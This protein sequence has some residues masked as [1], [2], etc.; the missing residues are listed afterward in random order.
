MKTVEISGLKGVLDTL[1]SLPQEVVFKRGSPVKLALKRGAQVIRDEEKARLRALQ[2][3][4]GRN[5]VT[6]LIEKNLIDTRGKPPTE[7]KG[8]RYVVRIKKKLYVGRKGPAVSTVKAAQIF[9]YGAENNSQPARPFIRTAFQAKAE[10]AINVIAENL[11]ARVNRMVK[12]MANMNK[13]K[14]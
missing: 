7:F 2:N 3:E 11:I 5:D 10:E 14:K 9:E 1:T 8:E 6:G 4:M 12:D 13:G